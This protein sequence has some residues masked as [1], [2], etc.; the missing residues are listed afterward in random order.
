MKTGTFLFLDFTIFAFPYLFF[1]RSSP[2]PPLCPF[3][4]FCQQG[5]ENEKDKVSF[6]GGKKVVWDITSNEY[7]S[8]FLLEKMGIFYLFLCLS[9]QAIKKNHA[10]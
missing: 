9:K 8:I 6:L 7:V 1:S 3:L 5:R 2:L 4:L 10:I